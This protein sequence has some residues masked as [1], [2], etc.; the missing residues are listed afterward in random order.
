MKTVKRSG[1]PGVGGGGE[2]INRWSTEDFFREICKLLILGGYV[3]Q[4]KFI[5]CKKGSILCEILIVQEVV[6]ACQEEYMGTSV[7]AA[8]FCY[9]LKTS[10]KINILEGKGGRK[11]G[12]K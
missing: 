10:L 12:R 2:W 9:E 5:D 3:C 1:L 6:H 8:Q 4:Y 11:R 7:L